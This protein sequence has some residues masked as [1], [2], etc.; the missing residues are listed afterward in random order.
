MSQIE[1]RRN[2]APQLNRR[3]FLAGA[4]VCLSL[5]LLEAMLPGGKTAFAQSFTPGRMLVFFTGNG[6]HMQTFTPGSAGAFTDGFRG[7][8]SLNPLRDIWADVTTIK[9]LHNDP[10]RGQTGDHGKGSGAFMTCA[11][12]EKNRIS[13]HTTMDVIAARQIA[14]QTKFANL[15]L[16]LEQVGSGFPDNGYSAAYMGNISWENATTPV[17]KEIDPQRLFNRIFGGDLPTNPGGVDPAAINKSVLDAIWADVDRLERKL[18]V[19]DREKLQGYV[20]G[21]RELEKKISGSGQGGQASSACAKPNIGSNGNYARNSRLMNDLMVMAFT[22]DLT[23][24]ISYAF[25]NGMSGRVYSNLGIGGGHHN[26]SHHGGRESNYVELR[27][28]DTYHMEEFAD[29]C[30]KLK[31]Q[32]DVQ[33]QSL[34]DSCMVLYSSE[35]ADGNTHSHYDLPVVLVGKGNGKIRPGRHMTTSSGKMAD[36]FVAMMQHVGANVTSFGNS[37]GPLNLA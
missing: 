21:V 11:A 27:A 4:G 13:S 33:G 2:K 32:V 8:T 29:L 6:C 16:G 7:A 9:G 18:G 22:C 35:I 24:V 28:I 26:I 23:R 14:S 25:S 19:N 10:M 15:H 1:L 36:L 12:V 37:T 17:P 3:S 30:K 34:L 5:P 31:A 20:S